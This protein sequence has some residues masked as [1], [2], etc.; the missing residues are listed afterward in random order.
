MACIGIV[1]YWK[2][3]TYKVT[4]FSDIIYVGM[5]FLSV[6]FSTSLPNSC[7]ATKLIVD[8]KAFERRRLI[9]H[10]RRLPHDYN[11]PCM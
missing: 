4:M 1:C 11:R 2:Y 3:T 10:R 7:K 6:K 5:F 9:E 8:H